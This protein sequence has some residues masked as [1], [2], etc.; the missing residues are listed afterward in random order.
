MECRASRPRR[1]HLFS[2]LLSPSNMKMSARTSSCSSELFNSVR[3]TGTTT[4]ARMWPS[5][6]IIATR[7]GTCSRKAFGM[8][9]VRLPELNQHR[10]SHAWLRLRKRDRA[11]QALRPWVMFPPLQPTSPHHHTVSQ[12]GPVLSKPWKHLVLKKWFIMFCSINFPTTL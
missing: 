3:E 6:A 10:F 5:G 12:F 8:V 4:A 11:L 2:K 7:T 9:R 1:F